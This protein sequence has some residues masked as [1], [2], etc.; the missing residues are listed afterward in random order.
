MPHHKSRQFKR[1]QSQGKS[2]T[3]TKAATPGV[4]DWSLIESRDV[5]RLEPG[6]S[7]QDLLDS[8]PGEHPVTVEVPAGQG[9]EAPVVISRP[10]TVLD[11]HPGAPRTEVREK[12]DLLVPTDD[13]FTLLQGAR[14]ESVT[15]G[16]LQE[17]PGVKSED[18]A[19]VAVRAYAPPKEEEE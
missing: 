5:V 6:T 13:G 12:V 11:F 15:R 1:G 2:C 4:T 18:V 7:L 3:I 17:S 10:Y 19:F 9:G 14:V 8:I 16:D